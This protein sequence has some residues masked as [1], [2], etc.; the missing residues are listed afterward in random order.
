MKSKNL[1][2]P[3][4]RNKPSEAIRQAIKDLRAIE[5]KRGCYV[6]DMHHF[7]EPVDGKCQV[8]LAGAVMAQTGNNPMSVLYPETFDDRKVEDKLMALDAF[9]C[10][11]IEGGL[12]RFGKTTPRFLAPCIDIVNY[13]DDPALFKKQMLEMA[14]VLEQHKL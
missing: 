8:C 7:H 4:I 1:K 12:G 5:R 2:T 13:E 9:R 6:I 3:K 14:K 10:G 11:D